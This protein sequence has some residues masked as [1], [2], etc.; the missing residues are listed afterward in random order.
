MNTIQSLGSKIKAARKSKKMTQSDLA[1][2]YITRAMLSKIENNVA[3]PSLETI[4]QIAYRL[5]LP[6]SYF[7]DDSHSLSTPEKNKYLI[8]YEQISFLYKSKEYLKAIDYFEKMLTPSDVDIEND[9]YYKCLLLATYC[10]YYIN[11]NET[12]Y[13][14]IN[15]LK[16]YFSKKQD[17]YYLSKVFHL[18]SILSFY[19][20]EY[21]V[22]IENIQNAIVHYNKSYIDDG[23]FQIELY[24][25]LGYAFFEKSN[26]PQAQSTLK[27][28]LQLS[29]ETNS[30]YRTGEML[31]LL[32]SCHKRLDNISEA[33]T[34]TSKAIKC[35]EVLDNRQ[36]IASCNRNIALLYISNGA[37]NSSLKHLSYALSY[38]ESTNNES[39]QSIIKADMAKIFV[40]Q[41]AYDKAMDISNEVVIDHLSNKE[42][43]EFYVSLSRI[44]A[45]L[46][47]VDKSMEILFESEKILS[48]LNDFILLK[49][50][51]F[52]EIANLYSLED[53]F[54]NAYLYSNKANA[55]SFP[56]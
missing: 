53:D 33:I 34:N 13:K 39:Y 32:G 15:V 55:L 23:I 29:K 47:N 20:S 51:V 46:G 52:R 17:H 27:D 26:F 31:M 54:K 41:E 11:K 4:K 45:H 43:V 56:K 37:L 38:Y 49:S 22:T 40:Q 18:T 9:D 24:Y 16:D 12:A 19:K 48:S 6:V 8:V 2:D 10:Y 3:K 35:F 30:L 25:T 28:A 36:L 1:G 50:T 21:N 14:N 7:I 42:K 5:E 44:Q